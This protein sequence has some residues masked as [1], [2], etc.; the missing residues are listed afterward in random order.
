MQ[1][2]LNEHIKRVDRIFADFDAAMK[3][4]RRGDREA[5]ERYLLV[6]KG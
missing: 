3:A 5:M 1:E 6:G 2:V 4:L